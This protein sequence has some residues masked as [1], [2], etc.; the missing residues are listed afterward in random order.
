M[1][2]VL[3][4]FFSEKYSCQFDKEYLYGNKERENKIKVIEESHQMSPDKI[5]PNTKHIFREANRVADLL[6]KKGH[7]NSAASLDVDVSTEPL[8]NKLVLLDSLG[9]SLERRVS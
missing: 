4:V 7:N 2:R 5:R 1:D 3:Y 6:S 9:I 8:L